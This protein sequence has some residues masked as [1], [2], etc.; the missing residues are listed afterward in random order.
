MR[1]ASLLVCINSEAECLDAEP[2][3]RLKPTNQPN[4]L[5][6]LL[7]PAPNHALHQPL[8]FLNML[9]QAKKPWWCSG[10]HTRS[11]TIS[12]VSRFTHSR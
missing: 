10:Q 11:L 3:L 4:S 1:V 6:R 2:Y 7:L 9:S 5:N 8:Y 12:K